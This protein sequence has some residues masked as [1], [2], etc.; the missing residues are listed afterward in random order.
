MAKKSLIIA[1][2][3]LVLL[4]GTVAAVSAADTTNDRVIVTSGSGTVIVSPD[5]AEVSL[6]VQTENT[7]AKTAQQMNAAQ[8]NSCIAALMAAGFTKDQLQTSG[9]SISP[10]YDDSS[11]TF[12]SKVKTY[13]VT[14]TLTVKL[15]DI[16]QTGS[17]VDIAV[18]NGANDVNSI[19]FLLSE[20]QS[21]AAR[22]VALQKAVAQTR[23]D[24]DTVASSL[25]VQVT[26]VQS[27]DVNQ[28]YTP[29]AYKS[30]AMDSY[31]AGRTSTP[32]NP[33]DL[34]V[35]ASVTVTYAIQ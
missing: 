21:Q 11:S 7:D 9:Y 22:T 5:R 33:S 30:L 25:G 12:G 2:A 24:A 20:E 16:N 29:V 26:R 34:T 15:T 3:L 31:A 6:G 17:V 35:T 10:I 32:I 14:N 19:Q 4:A 18:A 27:V 1:V 8:M 13:R 23:A 28:G